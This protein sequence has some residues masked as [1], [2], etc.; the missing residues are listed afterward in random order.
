[1]VDGDYV[2]PRFSL[3]GD[4]LAYAEV[5]MVG[6]RESTQ[7]WLLDL[8]SNDARLLLRSDSALAR[9]AAYAAS[10]IR[11][12]WRGDDTV[13][14]AISDG[15]VGQTEV[16]LSARTGSVL[17][18]E[19]IEPDL[20]DELTGLEG[21]AYQRLRALRPDWPDLLAD[22]IARGAIYLDSDR[23][24][25]QKQYSGEDNNV[26]LADLAENSF[27]VLRSLPD[28]SSWEMSGG[29]VH[30]DVAGLVGMGADE[31]ELLFFKDGRLTPGLTLPR[32]SGFARL[33]TKRVTSERTAFLLRQ[34]PNSREGTNYLLGLGP[35]GITRLR[36]DPLLFDADLSS[37]GQ[38]IAVNRWRD[39]RRMVELVRVGF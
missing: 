17:R 36:D 5:T 20:L 31:V 24:I 21:Q 1:M 14:A 39:G 19:W 29:L 27:A 8:E 35:N 28:A 7:V 25:F 18:E 13:V 12:D 33:E 30:E 37:D 23:L 26:W 32:E 11:L 34:G 10:I 38:W 6:D 2:F 4:Q 16:V 22:H 3:D 9:Y 15:D